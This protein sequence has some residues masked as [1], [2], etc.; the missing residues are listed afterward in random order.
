[1]RTAKIFLR[2][3]LASAAALSI[4][5]SAAWAQQGVTGMVTKIDRLNGKIAVQQTQ[6]GT[7]GA[8]SRGVTEEYKVQDAAMLDTVHAGDNVTFS[9][10][11]DH[12]S[13]AI[14]K[15]QKQK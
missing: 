1:M 12:G 2:I 15:L 9:V 8:N 3:V 5:M 10:A 14:T 7:V 4:L 11:E 6:D 13:K